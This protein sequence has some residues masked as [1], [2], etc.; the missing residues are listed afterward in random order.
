MEECKYSTSK[1]NE[2]IAEPGEKSMT[3]A[4]NADDYTEWDNLDI[5]NWIMTLGNGLF[6][7]YKDILRKSLIEENV[8]GIHLVNV[9]KADIKGWGVKDFE[10]K[11]ILFVN[12]KRLIKRDQ[13]QGN[14]A[15][16]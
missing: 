7:Q 4:K 16:L 10:H 1:D 3:F 8:R 2:I 14:T 11:Q 6:L 12:I 9:D 15:F 13:F 5:L